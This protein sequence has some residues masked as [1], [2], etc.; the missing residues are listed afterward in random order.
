MF[1]ST[2]FLNGRLYPNSATPDLFILDFLDTNNS[3]HDTGL[4]IYDIG[5]FD[6]EERSVVNRAGDCAE[7]RRSVDLFMLNPGR[8]AKVIR[9]E[10]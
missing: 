7:L 5:A 8:V 9:K 10:N 2:S 1:R 6:F 4:T 3:T